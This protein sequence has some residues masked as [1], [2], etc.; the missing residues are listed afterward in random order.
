[1]VTKKLPTIFRSALMVVCAFASA[2]ASAQQATEYFTHTAKLG[3]TLIGLANRYLIDA[4]NWQSIQNQNKI[5]DP[6]RIK[7]GAE[8][9]IPIRLMRSE[10]ATAKVIA[11]QGPVETT[12]G[13]LEKGA[14]LNEGTAIKTGENGFVTLQLADGSTIV[15]QSK[16]QVK[17]DVARVLAN[18]G[19]VPSTTIALKS[20]RVE[21][22]VEKRKG[23]GARFEVSTPTSNMGV[24]GTRFRVSADESGKVSRGEVLEGVVAVASAAPA[25]KPLDLG[26]GFGSVVEAGK[27]ASAPVALLAAPDLSATPTLQERIALRFKFADVAGAIGYRGQVATDSAFSNLLADDVFKTAE[28]KFSNLDDGQYFF[29]ARA[30]DK[31]ALEGSDAVRAFKLKA[32]PEPPF[33]SEPKNKNKLA[34]EKVEFKWANSVEAGS[35]RF[36]LASN[37]DFSPSISD[38]RGVVLSNSGS[39]FSPSAAIKP[40]DYFWRVASV[41]PD[42]DV[43]PFGDTQS[44]TLKAL[45]QA[46]NPPKEEGNRVG[47]SWSGEPNQIFDFQLASDA[48]FKTIVQD[49]KLTQPEITIE[50]P[51]DAGTYYMRYRSIDADGFIGPYSSAQT[52]EV[53]ANRWW[54]L[55]LLVPFLL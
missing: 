51:A 7:P 36:Q 42:G 2:L 3:D 8:I 34:A 6:L 39:A 29:R 35:Y 13:A 54:L 1:M 21:S 27:A 45:P 55:L 5:P 38:E 4:K 33:T 31:S 12:A 26:A 11:V 32:R 37:A 22:S 17:L 28:A 53:K 16:S 46:P 15:V 52:I 10:P 9:R 40:G 24:R 20:G 49:K 23:Q 50:K 18:T 25:P 41:R 47:F 43:G 30:I 44:F 14:V 19:G 48:E